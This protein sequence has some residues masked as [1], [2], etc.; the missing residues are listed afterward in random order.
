MHGKLAIVCA[1]ALSVLATEAAADGYY[2]GGAP[3]GVPVPAPIPVPVYEPAWYF[4]FDAS[5][6]FNN[7]LDAT[8]KGLVFGEGNST[9]STVPFGA[10]PSW[11]A[12]H[13]SQHAMYGAGVGYRWTHS[14]RTD[15]TAE[16]M[17][18]RGVSIT[19][20][21]DA[22]PLIRSGTG[23]VPGTYDVSTRD[24]TSLRAVV[25]LA[26][27]YYDFAG[28]GP[29]TPYVGGGVGVAL[30]RAKRHNVTTE[31][32]RET[33]ED[34]VVVTN[35]TSGD[36]EN[37][38]VLAAAATAGLSFAI[39]SSISLDLSYRYLYLGGMYADL[40]VNNERTR[41]QLD[42]TNDQQLRLGVRFGLD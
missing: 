19:A 11:L 8:E 42:S 34:A 1:C 38:Y 26:N 41:V 14:I 2:A 3:A 37:E 30:A 22:T 40:I 5:L 13:F 12:E 29:V 25:M 27:A 4:R 10:A 20:D 7:D 17:R 33:G 39:N 15:I 16:S 35:V 21:V 28:W 31:V 6:G 32:A 23:V 24:E 36:G 18:E 9:Y